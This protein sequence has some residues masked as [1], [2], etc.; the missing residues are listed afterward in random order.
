MARKKRVTQEVPKRG[1]GR[2]SAFKPEYVEQVRKLC[3]LGATDPELADFFGVSHYTID[4]WS[5]RHPEFLAA[6]K[7]GK[8]A[9]DDRVE[10][11][12][13][14]RAIGYAHGEKVLPDT[15]AQ[16]FWLKNRRRLEWR[17]RQDHEVTGK[18]GAP[19]IP[20]INLFGKPDKDD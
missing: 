5:M 1:R 2:P 6:K 9:L 20:V 12:L 10:R 4:N 11:S 16:I 14:H 15:T 8:D 3:E 18:D 13:F 19:L 17:D 7:G